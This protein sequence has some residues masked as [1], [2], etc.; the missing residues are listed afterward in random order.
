MGLIFGIVFSLI[1]SKS[2]KLVVDDGVISFFTIIKNNDYSRGLVLK[3]SLISNGLYLFLVW[4]L[5]ISIIG[6][7][8]IVFMLFLR[9]FILGFSI[10]SIIRIYGYKGI[11][12]GLLYLFPHN[13]LSLVISALLSFYALS[14]SIRLF[15]FLFLHD[16]I[17][18]KFIM[19]KYIKILVICL[20]AFVFCS[21]MEVYLSPI[22]LNIF[23]LII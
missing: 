5:G 16:N 20:F 1:I 8:V 18:F 3:E 4:F 7:P 13:I 22:I 10:G 2:D 21:L 6:I 12:G 11:V 9:G 23:N 15:K 17:N 14:F 19:K